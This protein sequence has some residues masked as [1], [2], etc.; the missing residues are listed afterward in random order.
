MA[1]LI[2]HTDSNFKDKIT[3]A[4]AEE[5][6]REVIGVSSI[7]EACG[8]IDLLD[9]FSFILCES[10]L[11]DSDS[12]QAIEDFINTTNSV[13]SQPLYFILG[14]GSGA[15]QA[16]VV[17]LNEALSSDHITK[18]L[19]SSIDYKEDHSE[20]S[21]VPMGLLRYLENFPCEMFI[22]MKKS[23]Q[24]KYVKRFLGADPIEQ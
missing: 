19:L 2:I 8:F 3:C 17:Q 16:N 13:K 20:F 23:E 22:K 10:Q 1:L 5:T 21:S 6:N 4:I 11:D 9:N 12:Y 7:E 15:G 18:H 24:E 14:E